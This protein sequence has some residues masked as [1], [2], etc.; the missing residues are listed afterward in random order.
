MDHFH[1]FEEIRRRLPAAGK[2]PTA[3]DGAFLAGS[4]GCF[5]TIGTYDGV[6]RGH[7]AILSPLVEKAHAAGAKAVVVTFHPHPIVLLRGIDQPYYLNTPEERAQ[8]L[9]DLGI[10]AVVTLTFDRALAGLTADEFMQQMSSA[11]NLREL[12]VGSDFALGRNRQGDITALAEIGRR[13][14][15]ELRIIPLA[16]QVDE[17]S[18]A[19]ERI[20]SSRIRELVRAGQV[21][22]AAQMLGRPY[23]LE[24]PVE[25]G[26]A[27]GRGL[28]FPTANVAYWSEKITPAYGVYATWAWLGPRRIPS[29]TSVGVRPTF[30]NPPSLPR[31]EAYL[32]DFDE[33]LYG[34]ELRVEFLEFLRPEL[35]FNS[36]E[37]LIDQMILDTQNARE[38][39]AHAA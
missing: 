29:V 7:Q 11:L 32:I 14:G 16:G 4:A 10:D 20:S 23:A 30:D 28:G 18:G 1:S 39:L 27:R 35:R 36:A 6:H 9:G 5:A 25:H 26:E 24:G 8:L 13:L 17:A 3:P 38:V 37:E 34:K 2:N 22:R 12:W 33:D 31:V 19:E 15:Y 21:S